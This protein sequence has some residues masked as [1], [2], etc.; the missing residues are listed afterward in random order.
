MSTNQE[1]NG[2]DHHQQSIHGFM[3]FFTC[4]ACVKS[5]VL[6]KMNVN[7]DHTGNFKENSKKVSH[8][9]HIK[10]LSLTGFYE[11]HTVWDIAA[12]GPMLRHNTMKRLWLLAMRKTI[13]FV[14]L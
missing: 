10:L 3:I 11:L 9:K 12:C 8:G 14:R 2:R 4:P 5:S 6:F 1:M 13:K 7:S